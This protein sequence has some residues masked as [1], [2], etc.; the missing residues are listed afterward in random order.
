MKQMSLLM[1]SMKH[2]FL[3]IITNTH[4]RIVHKKIKVNRV[5]Q[6]QQKRYQQ[7]RMPLFRINSNI[8]HSPSLTAKS[9]TDTLL[10]RT[11]S[12]ESTTGIKIR[13]K[14][15]GA[16]VDNSSSNAANA[17]GNANLSTSTIQNGNN[18]QQQ[19]G[20]AFHNEPKLQ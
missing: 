1:V 18:A 7:Q 14:G 13:M 5:S 10:N 4:V 6:Q 20:N 8:I 16:I 9:S 15:Y 17:A 19:Q 11:N 2:F 12:S 3:L